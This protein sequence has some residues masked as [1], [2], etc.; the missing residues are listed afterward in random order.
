MGENY[1]FSNWQSNEIF[2]AF[3]FDMKSFISM[4]MRQ[5]SISH[6]NSFKFANK[7]C[8]Q[9]LYF[10]QSYKMAKQLSKV[11]T[12][13]LCSNVFIITIITIYI[14]QNHLEFYNEHNDV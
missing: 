5:I 12:Y 10:F 1:Y 11:H 8:V 3:T 9:M 4:L 13:I 2:D 14:P 6:L 7:I